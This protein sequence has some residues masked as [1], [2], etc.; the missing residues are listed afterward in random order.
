[1]NVFNIPVCIHLV[2]V[3]LHVPPGTCVHI[4]HTC[5]VCHMYSNRQGL[6]TAP[7]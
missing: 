3:V 6:E 2:E 5:V 7:F 1:M 4:P